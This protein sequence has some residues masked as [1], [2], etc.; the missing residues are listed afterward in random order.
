MHCVIWMLIGTETSNQNLFV[1]PLLKRSYENKRT[2]RKICRV[3]VFL[4]ENMYYLYV[5]QNFYLFCVY[6][7]LQTVISFVI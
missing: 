5:E 6:G 4:H 3:V 1:I 2:A 7:E